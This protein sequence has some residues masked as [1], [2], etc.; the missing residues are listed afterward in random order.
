MGSAS[1]FRIPTPKP[2]HSDDDAIFT[3]EQT[4]KIATPD[5]NIGVPS[6]MK[7]VAVVVAFTHALGLMN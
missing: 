2:T 7:I 3:A 4:E 5:A 6:G 1:S